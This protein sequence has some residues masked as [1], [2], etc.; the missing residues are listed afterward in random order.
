MFRNLQKCSGAVARHVIVQNEPN[1]A[2]TRDLGRPSLASI[3]DPN[4]PDKCKFLG[5]GPNGRQPLVD[6][7]FIAQA[8]HRAPTQLWTKLPD[9]A[10]RNVILALRSTRPI[11]PYRGNW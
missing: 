5:R 4:S 7:A 11:L 3:V 6:A 2:R 1:G 10:R 9:D 8:I